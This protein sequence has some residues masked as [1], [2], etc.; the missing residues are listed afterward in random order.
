MSLPSTAILKLYDRR[1]ANDLRAFHDAPKPS[2]T[3]EESFRAFMSKEGSRRSL[4]DWKTKIFDDQNTDIE[5]PPEETEAFLAVLLASYHQNEVHV[6]ERLAFMQGN[7]IPL[8]FG[9]TRFKNSD[10]HPD[11]IDVDVPGILIEYVEGTGLDKLPA[12][13]VSP[14]LCQACVDIVLTV[15]DHD[16]LNQDVRLQNFIVPSSSE[17]GRTVVMIDFAQA[18]LRE[19]DEDDDQWKQVKWTIDEEGAVGYVLRKKFGWDY[20]PTFRYLVPAE[21]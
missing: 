19:N 11:T 4:D 21:E 5:T 7:S 18:R 15:G 9:Q 8:F 1:F 6:Y 14:T 2:A 17:S 10:T 13:A 12:S 16:V 3:S 20:Q